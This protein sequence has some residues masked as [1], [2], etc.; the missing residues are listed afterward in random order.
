M[1]QAEEVKLKLQAEEAKLKLL[2]QRAAVLMRQIGR[3]FAPANQAE[4]Q[5]KNE[6][7]DQGGDKP[8]GQTGPYLLG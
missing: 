5:P 7:Q 4:E 2:E 3:T 1:R 8:D 6:P